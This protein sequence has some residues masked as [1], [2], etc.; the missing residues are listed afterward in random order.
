MVVPYI[1]PQRRSL[2][3]PN[4]AAAS[5]CSICFYQIYSF[6]S[7]V[8]MRGHLCTDDAFRSAPPSLCM[9]PT[10]ANVSDLPFPIQSVKSVTSQLSNS[11]VNGRWG[12][13]WITIKSIREASRL[14]K[15]KTWEAALQQL[16]IFLHLL[17]HLVLH[18]HLLLHLLMKML[19]LEA[20]LQPLAT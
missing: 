20:A 17:D 13:S 3:W 14:L 15:M 10:A 18:L 12:A 1:A 19:V 9:L 6:S 7:L 11:N 5:P 4:T 2:D 16:Q 8:C